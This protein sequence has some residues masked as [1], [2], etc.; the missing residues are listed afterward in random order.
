MK[1]FLYIFVSLTFALGANSQ[2]LDPNCNFNSEL[3]DFVNGLFDPGC[4]EK[5][6][7]TPRCECLED[8]KSDNF[9]IGELDN[10]VNIKQYQKDLAEKRTKDFW[11]VYS[12]MTSGAALQKQM[13][14]GH[15]EVQSG[16]KN[17]KVVGCPPVEVA[18]DF[19]SKLSEHMK[20]VTKRRKSALEDVNTALNICLAE[21]RKCTGLQNQK[22]TLEK[23]LANNE[24]EKHEL[25]ESTQVN[26]K[27]SDAQLQLQQAKDWYSTNNVADKDAKLKKISCYLLRLDIT[28]GSNEETYKNSGCTALTGEIKLSTAGTVDMSKSSPYTFKFDVTPIQSGSGNTY[29]DQA[30]S[31][32]ADFIQV[33]KEERQN[34]I[35][36]GHSRVQGNSGLG[37]VLGAGIKNSFKI[38][39]C[40]EDKL[41]KS[42]EDTNNNALSTLEE[43]F[44][45][46]GNNCISYPEYLLK[47]GI[48][49]KSFLAELA[50]LPVE[51]LADS[52]KTPKVLKTKA[53]KERLEFLRSNPIVAKLAV[54][55]TNRKLMAEALQKLAKG[56]RE[57]SKNQRLD[58]YLGFMK[59]TVKDL[60]KDE[61]FKIQEQYICKQM[62]SS[63]TEIQV[64]T[65]LPPLKEDGSDF[66]LQSAI[67]ECKI[68]MNNA[69]SMTQSEDS[70][71][72][73]DLFRE[74]EDLTGEKE[75]KRS[76]I[77]KFQELNRI[78][79]DGYKDFLKKC[80]QETEVCRR[81]FRQNGQE[82]KEEQD[83]FDKWNTTTDPKQINF[84]D[85]VNQS[86]AS[87]QDESFKRWWDRKIGSKMSKSPFPYKGDLDEFMLDKKMNDSKVAHTSLPDEYRTSSNSSKPSND[88]D[89]VQDSKN[90]SLLNPG[91]IVP[92]FANPVPA[93][94][95]D[96][97]KLVP[98][99]SVTNAITNFPSL[100]PAEKI[101]GL[102]E[103]QKYLA[104]QKGKLDQQD[105]EE[106]IAETKEKIAEEKAHQRDLEK[107][108]QHEPVQ[109]SSAPQFSAAVNKTNLSN[110]SNGGTGS[111]STGGSVS[112]NATINKSAGGANAINEA[113]KSKEEANSR[114]PASIK[115]EDVQVKVGTVK[116]EELTGKLEITKELTPATSDLFLQMSRDPGALEQ[117]LVANLDK[118]D[119][120]N[121]KIISIL[122][123]GTESPVH[124]MIFKI[125]MVGGKYI[126]QSMP[127]DVKVTR[128]STLK[129]LNMNIKQIS[130]PKKAI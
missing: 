22:S 113:L 2:P 126:I 21:R 10:K 42:F 122:N 47:K 4:L 64:A 73:N 63:F 87:S 69:M 16:G 6:A 116:P 102:Q 50:N 28:S 120:G 52:L 82:F 98:G 92:S 8:A 37:G 49:G 76:D 56:G 117:Y 45:Q 24:D 30:C 43:N 31:E 46:D 129:N 106:K 29:C 41:C 5:P 33:Y 80:T 95:F 17:N 83:I 20:E 127:Q 77:E 70:L 58:D 61:N 15:D 11:K 125:T 26:N 121:G 57:K 119:I 99:H 103:A 32:I 124:H 62:I 35:R 128:S 130:K 123:P 40:K 114:G 48:P 81:A 108:M 7:G 13:I 66:P 105:L 118:K 111:V 59:T 60:M 79:C 110:V 12:Q 104:E 115:E 107:R 19:K 18:E 78:K 3:N 27:K 100:P 53:D 109:Q 89:D 88:T 9:L 54:D 85:V 36:A 38:A 71:K 23:A 72:M 93:A 39:D 74:P 51:K 84:G 75:D 96:P 68:S 67:R 44:Q 112:K 34:V 1:K 101:A 91:Q 97:A 55:E 25:E 94:T 86:R 90:S 14:F 65:D